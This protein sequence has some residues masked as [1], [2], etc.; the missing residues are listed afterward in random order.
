[1]TLDIHESN[2]IANTAVIIGNVQIEKKCGVFPN[3]VLRGDEN[4]IKIGEGSNVQDCAVI[5][6]N[7]EHRVNI[8]K[9]VSIGHSSVIHGSTIEDNVIIGM[10][11]TIMNG[12]KIGKGSII[13]ANA[14]VTEGKKIPS[15]SL[16][17]GV[18]GKIVK[19]DK[20]FEK[21]CIKNAEIYKKLS[22]DHKKGKYNY[23][24]K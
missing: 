9:N 5:H 6:V 16:V 3:A 7:S 12:A 21:I 23:Y 19:K 17:I 20:E 24:K 18:P 11:A 13:G 2:F 10:N 4:T 15:Y 1:M 14:L 8:G 22:M